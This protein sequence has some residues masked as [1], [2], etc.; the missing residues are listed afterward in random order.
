[1]RETKGPGHLYLFMYYEEAQYFEC[2][3]YGICIYV[4][5]SLRFLSA[6]YATEY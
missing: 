1:M 4:N 5:K 2:G 3:A 6:S